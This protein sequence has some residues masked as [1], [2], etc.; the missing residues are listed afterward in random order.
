MLALVTGCA[1]PIVPDPK[2]TVQEFARAAEAGDSVKIYAML[3]RGS[4][5]QYGKAGTE[6]LVG[7]AKVELKRL[8][9]TL[10]EGPTEVKTEAEV[11]F[12][13]GER[14]VLPVEA[15][16]FKVGAL[17][18][19]PAAARTP[20]QALSELR[21]VLARRSYSGMMRVLT[22][23]SRSALEADLRSLVVGLQD[24]E[25]LDVQVTGDTAEVKL[26]GGHLVKLKREDGVWRVEDFD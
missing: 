19:L 25:T 8:G 12:I 3:T 18:T 6:R 2:A 24:P 4:R 7:E 1:R 15:G 10:R 9:R 13:D 21:Q 14:A 5:Q 20:V 22:E 16:A 17:G 11:Y 26:P 23:D